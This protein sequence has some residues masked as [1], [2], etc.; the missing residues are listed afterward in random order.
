MCRPCTRRPDAR[1]ARRSP[2]RARAR[3][4]LRVSPRCPDGDWGVQPDLSAGRRRRGRVLAAAGDGLEDW[5]CS[6]GPRLAPP[7]REHS[8]VLA[9][10]GRLRRRRD[11]AHARAS[12]QVRA[13]THG[14]A[15]AHL[16]PAALH[17]IVF[18]RAHPRRSVS[19]RP[20]SRR[21]TAP[22]RTRSCTCRIR[23]A[24]S[25]PGSAS[26]PLA[27]LAWA[28]VRR[29]AGVLASIALTAAGVTAI[30]CAAP[31][32][33]FEHQGPSADWRAGSGVEPGRSIT[34]RLPRFIS[35]SRSLAFTVGSKGIVSAPDLTSAADRQQ[36]APGGLSAL[37]DLADAVRLCLHRQVER[38]FWSERWIEARS[39]L[40]ALA[41]RVRRQRIV[42][43]VEMDSGWWEDR[44]VT[45]VDQAWFRLDV[46]AL[47]EEH[48]SGKCLCRLAMRSRFTATPL[49]ALASGIAVVGWASSRRAD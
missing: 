34:A 18:G 44:D 33:A 35:C 31:R 23:A 27:I 26:S 42:R 45:I 5:L 9:P 12:P 21:S 19:D 48:E 25:S 16:Q 49:L 36:P 37:S 39:V 40:W 46:R 8:R 2:G 28:S 41:D 1:P 47:V 22:T 20:P 7:S 30:K 11:V 13:G 17:P 10:A 43:N 29:S 32:I 4:Q 24:G 38:T 3:L 14:V 6:I 15:G